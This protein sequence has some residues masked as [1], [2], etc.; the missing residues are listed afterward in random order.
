MGHQQHECREKLGGRAAG[1]W[2]GAE[3]KVRSGS[4]E[5]F[6]LGWGQVT[7]EAYTHSVSGEGRTGD[8]RDF[9]PFS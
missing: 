7:P 6:A 8:V 5:V 3:E 1:H 4:G 9:C 2:V